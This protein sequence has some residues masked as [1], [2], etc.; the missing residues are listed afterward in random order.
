MPNRGQAAKT[1]RQKVI[2][3]IRKKEKGAD[4]R[5]GFL[6]VGVCVVSPCSSSVPP[7]Y[8]PVKDW[9][10]MRSYNDDDLSDIG[11]PASRCGKITTKKADGNQEHVPDGT[12]VTYDDAPPAFGP[13]WNSAD[14]APATSRQA[15]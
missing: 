13:H 1:D 6:I 9:W 5:R 15:V 4:K 7:P 14:V 3:E 8:R 2:D 10:D 11:A 12:Q